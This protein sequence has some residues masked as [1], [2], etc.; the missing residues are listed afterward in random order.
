MRKQFIQALINTGNY[1]IVLA[2]GEFSNLPTF[3][4]LLK[5]AKTLISCD[6]ATGHLIKHNIEPDVIIG[7]C[8][9]LNPKIMVRYSQKIIKIAE[10][11]SNDLTKAINYLYNKKLDTVIILG[12]TGKRED[13][14]LANI[15][16]LA[17]YSKLLRDVCIISR[18][19]VFTVHNGVAQ[20]KCQI[21]QQ[22]S[23]FA[24]NNNTRIS[25]AELK[26][27]LDKFNL[28]NWY[29]GTLNQATAKMINI[30]TNS[31]VILYRSFEIKP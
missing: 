11:D 18:Y 24:I 3:I 12:A 7:D 30:E 19:G 2:D 23:F 4:S 21:G 27:P 16:L 6:G 26:W 1:N 5:N 13:H 10:Q 14:T 8:D 15:A 29:N 28:S 17:E 22:I 20:I 31:H 25:C 9:S